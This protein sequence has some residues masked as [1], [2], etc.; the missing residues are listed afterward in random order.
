MELDACIEEP[1]KA[2]ADRKWTFQSGLLYCFIGVLPILKSSFFSSTDKYAFL[3]RFA[4]DCRN[5]L[6]RPGKFFSAGELLKIWQLSYDQNVMLL[7]HTF[8]KEGF[9]IKISCQQCDSNPSH[10]LQNHPTG[11]RLLSESCC[12][13]HTLTWLPLT[14]GLLSDKNR[15][16]KLR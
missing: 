2:V 15:C 3:E 12:F 10:G 11:F 8:F 14:S 13:D 16:F 9:K 7:R 1:R 6:T 4:S 5:L